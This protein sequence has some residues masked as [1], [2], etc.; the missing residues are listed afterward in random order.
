MEKRELKK[1]KTKKQTYTTIGNVALTK[2]N[3]IILSAKAT[4]TEHGIKS[5]LLNDLNL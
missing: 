4:K 3:K 1:T 2:W 5:I